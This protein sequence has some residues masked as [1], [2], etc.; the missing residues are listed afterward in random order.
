MAIFFSFEFLNVLEL[1]KVFLKVTPA[2]ARPQQKE[3]SEIGVLMTDLVQYAAFYFVN[4][5][6][7]SSFLLFLSGYFTSFKLESRLDFEQYL[8]VAKPA[9]FKKPC[10]EE[11]FYLTFILLESIQVTRSFFYEN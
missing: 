5:D 9:E 3:S 2:L 10:N 1:F 4:L 7:I 11:L 6:G 8:I